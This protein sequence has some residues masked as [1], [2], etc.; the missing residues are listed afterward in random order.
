MPVTSY[1]SVVIY[2][3]GLLDGDRNRLSPGYVS[4]GILYFLTSDQR[5]SKS[6]R[7]ANTVH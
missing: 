3:E 4:S 7:S 2:E 5:S 6:L 1:P